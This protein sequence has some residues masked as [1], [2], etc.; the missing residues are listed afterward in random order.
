MKR[1]RLPTFTMTVAVL[2][3]FAYQ[4]RANLPSV[5]DPTTLIINARNHVQPFHYA[6]STDPDDPSC[7][8]PIILV[9]HA[10][11]AAG[12]PIDGLNIEASVSMAMA[13]QTA[14]KVKL[15]S[16]G[17]GNYEGRVSLEM[18]GT[19]DVDLAGE[20]DGNRARQRL[21]VEVSPAHASTP[22]DDDDDDD[23]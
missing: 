13:D 14:Q 8:R 15:R 3:L 7:D 9:V 21:S 16:R 18:A 5:P 6:L 20:K 11:D 4:H 1:A 23:S 19:W 22:I 2:A 12:Q 17:H 10:V